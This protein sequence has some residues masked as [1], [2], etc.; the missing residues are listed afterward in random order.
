MPGTQ[1]IMSS[2]KNQM[3]ASDFLAKYGQLDDMQKM[4]ILKETNITDLSDFS[5]EISR[6]FITHQGKQ[7]FYNYVERFM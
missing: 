6:S 5:E 2:M 7:T 3:T 4:K 1:Q